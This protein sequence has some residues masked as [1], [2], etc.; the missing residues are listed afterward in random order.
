MDKSNLELTI[1]E[2]WHLSRVALARNPTV[3]SRHER[4][5]YIKSELQRTYP[6]LITGLS[7]KRLWFKICDTTAPTF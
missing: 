2:L 7:P 6:D 5:I 1:I 3:P 4:M